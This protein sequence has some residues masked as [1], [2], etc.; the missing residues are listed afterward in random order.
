MKVSALEFD[1]SGTSLWVGTGLGWV[2]RWDVA[3]RSM[4]DEPVRIGHGHLPAIW[5]IAYAPDGSAVAISTLGSDAALWNPETVERIGRWSSRPGTYGIW[6]SVRMA[7]PWQP[8]YSTI[9]QPRTA[10]SVLLDPMSG[11]ET[12]RLV[13]HTDAVFGIAF[14]DGDLDLVSGSADSTVRLWSRRTGEQLGQPMR[15]DVDYVNGVG[16]LA[17]TTSVLSAGTDGSVVS[18]RSEIVSS[19]K[20]EP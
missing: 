16:F 11:H 7:P 9:Q 4:I 13:G 2:T 20:A 12:G 1:P 10:P 15:N 19:V 18:W 3:T 5:A 14:A 17:G 8:V 6:S